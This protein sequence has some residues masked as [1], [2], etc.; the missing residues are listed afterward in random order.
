MLTTV[1]SNQVLSGAVV[2]AT[3]V[4]VLLLALILSISETKETAKKVMLSRSI[5]IFLIPLLILFAYLLILEIANIRI[6]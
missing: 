4:G 2:T 3:I 6:G 5:P 1:L